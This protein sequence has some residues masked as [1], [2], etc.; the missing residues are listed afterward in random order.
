KVAA[1]ATKIGRSLR[2]SDEESLGK[3][4]VRL[5]NAGFRQEQAIAVYF[6]TKLLALVLGLALS[7]PALVWKFGMTQTA[8]VLAAASEGLGFYL[9]DLII[10]RSKKRRQEAIFLGLP[11][12]LDLMVVCVEAGLGLDAAMRRVTGELGEACPV[13]CEEIA[14]SNFQIQ[15]GRP[16]KE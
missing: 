14:I 1:A 4:R 3:I 9:P 7:F 10:G 12:A 2:P 5:L 11:D 16:R 13:L 15:M 8:Y 6:G